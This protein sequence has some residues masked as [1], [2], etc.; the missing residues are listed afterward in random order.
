MMVESKDELSGWIAYA[1]CIER[2]AFAY[3]RRKRMQSATSD[4]ILFYPMFCSF[5]VDNEV[6]SSFS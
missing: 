3:E 5:I 1:T 4:L 2:Y 6:L